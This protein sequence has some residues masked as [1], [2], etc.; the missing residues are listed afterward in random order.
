[1]TS[2]N[3]GTGL[4]PHT[5][6]PALLKNN[7][8]LK[9]KNLVAAFEA[10]LSDFAALQSMHEKRNYSVTERLGE[11]KQ[12]FLHT[13]LVRDAAKSLLETLHALWPEENIYHP[14][15][16]ECIA[17]RFSGMAK[18]LP[19]SEQSDASSLIERVEA[20]LPS[21]MALES[22][23]CELEDG[24]TRFPLV[25]D[26]LP[27]LRKQTKLWAARMAAVDVPRIEQISNEWQTCSLRAGCAGAA[28]ARWV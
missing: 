14:A 8:T 12:S 27:V 21:V 7:F 15:S 16:R 11:D 17:V 18:R 6:V 5:S 3:N 25:V 24:M 22:A 9:F 26:I 28:R 20:E 1:M 2:T 4:I 10:Q 23:C 13:C 19:R